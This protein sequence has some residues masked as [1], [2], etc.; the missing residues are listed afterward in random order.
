MFWASL[1]LGKDIWGQFLLQ[2]IQGLPINMS[3]NKK[4]RRKG[5]KPAKN[6]HCRRPQSHPCNEEQTFYTPVTA[7]CCVPQQIPVRNM[8]ERTQQENLL[9]RGP[10]LVMLHFWTKTSKRSV[11]A[12]RWWRHLFGPKG[13]HLGPPWWWHHVFRPK[14]SQLGPSVGDVTFLVQRGSVGGPLG[15]I[16]FFDQRGPVVG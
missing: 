1:R 3:H 8:I 16:T 11:G 7:A 5:Q 9:S 14:R 6:G 4:L 10:P 15:D 2:N 13:S 12:P